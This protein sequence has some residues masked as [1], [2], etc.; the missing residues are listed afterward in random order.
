MPV[1]GKNSTHWFALVLIALG[2]LL[3]LQRLGA[4]SFGFHQV[5]WPLVMLFG[6]VRVAQGFSLSKRG[7]IFSGTLLFMYGLFFLLRFSDY[8]DIRLRMFLP[9]SL[10]IFGIALLMLFLDDAREWEL[11]IPA[12]LLFGT[13]SAFVL[14]ELGYLDQFE[15]WDAVHRYWPLGLILVG[16]AIIF[17]RRTQIQKAEQTQQV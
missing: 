13:G 4:I 14:T 16:L 1:F 7:R 12:L 9:A 6:L 5:L 11:L 10:L 2:I 3:L 8:I 17:R 15:V